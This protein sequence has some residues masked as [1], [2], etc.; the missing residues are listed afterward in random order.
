MGE[1]VVPH[2]VRRGRDEFVVVTGIGEQADHLAGFERRPTLLPL[3]VGDG[4]SK[5]PV[6]RLVV[7]G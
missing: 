7:G 3:L 1:Q 2:V 6:R 4:P 5:V